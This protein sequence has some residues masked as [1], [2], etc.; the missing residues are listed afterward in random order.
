MLTTVAA[1]WQSPRI[2]NPV[3]RLLSDEV[4]CWHPELELWDGA[5]HLLRCRGQLDEERSNQKKTA[6]VSLRHVSGFFALSGHWIETHM[7]EVLHQFC[8]CT[9]HLYIGRELPIYPVRWRSSQWRS[10]LKTWPLR[11]MEGPVAQRA[12]AS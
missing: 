3:A 2:C 5:T 12:F 1:G 8:S 11:S 7:M 9:R 4:S 6:A 10:S